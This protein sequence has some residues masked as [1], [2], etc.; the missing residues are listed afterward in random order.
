MTKLLACTT[1]TAVYNLYFHPLCKFPGPSWWVCS[2]IAPLLAFACGRFPQWLE[3]LHSKY[4][5]VV[6]FGPQNLAFFTPD[7]WQNI[8]G[9]DKQKA[10]VK[11]PRA[12][13]MPPAGAPDM[14]TANNADHRRYRTLVG[15]AFSDRA[16]REQQ[17]IV[18]SH[19]DLL[20]LKLKEVS[21]HNETVDIHQWLKYTTFDLIG[22][23]AFGEPFACL[24]NIKLHPWVAQLPIYIKSL[25]IVTIL[26]AWLPM[27]KILHRTPKFVFRTMYAHI[28]MTREKVKRRL[29]AGT[30][31][32]DFMH[33][34]LQNDETGMNDQGLMANMALLIIAGS[35]TTATTLAA[36]IYLLLK[37]PRALE[38]LNREIRTRFKGIQ[39]MTIDRLSAFEYL[40]AVIQEAMR[41]HAPVPIGLPR[42]VT[43]DDAVV[44]GYAVP[45]GVSSP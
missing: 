4:G 43:I 23:L 41:V 13:C 28:E 24:E 44:A 2:E 10:F 20:V 14:L 15:N 35:E 5:E 39:D 42:V 16:L 12:Y 11:D 18:E 32:K 40:N 8:Y 30:N 31:R 27:Q 1:Y 36:T 21:R 26:D 7:A 29:A 38:R 17:P 33:Y 22:E 19:V 45:G 3:R 25:A 6:R 37:N 34:I 9:Q